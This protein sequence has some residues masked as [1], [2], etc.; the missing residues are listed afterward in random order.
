MKQSGR[1]RNIAIHTCTYTPVASGVGCISEVASYLGR[2]SCELDVDIA[3]DCRYTRRVGLANAHGVHHSIART[4]QVRVLLGSG[5]PPC[6][7]PIPRPLA[8]RAVRCSDAAKS[9]A[10]LGLDLNYMRLMMW[11]PH[12][13]TR[14]ERPH[15]VRQATLVF[16]GALVRLEPAVPVAPLTDTSGDSLSAGMLP[17]GNPC[18]CGTHS[19]ISSNVAPVAPATWGMDEAFPKENRI[20]QCHEY[21]S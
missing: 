21:M 8:A 20:Y 12:R 2:D 1:L 3:S 15:I 17:V 7:D 5:A 11:M 4:Y 6:R 14:L 9:R 13:A 19:P 16:D 18:A 10:L